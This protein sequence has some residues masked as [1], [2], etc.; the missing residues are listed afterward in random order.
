MKWITPSVCG[1]TR[2]PRRPSTMTKS[3]RAPSRPGMGSM[4]NTA[5]LRERKA[6]NCSR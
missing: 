2:R 4:L 1:F 6:V 5:R 3:S